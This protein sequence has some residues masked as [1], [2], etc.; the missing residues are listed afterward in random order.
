MESD[1]RKLQLTLLEILDDVIEVFESNNV[2]Y[3]IG[4]G[5]ALGAVRHGGFIP[6]DDD[7]DIAVMVDDEEKMRAAL[8]KLDQKKYSV[9]YPL[10]GEFGE[11]F[12]LVSKKGTTHIVW[13]RT[14]RIQRISIEIFVMYNVPDKKWERSIHHTLMRSFEF[15]SNISACSDSNLVNGIIVKTMKVMT[16]LMDFISMKSKEHYVEPRNNFF[17]RDLMKKEMYGTPRILKFENREICFPEHLEEYL[18]QFYGDYMQ[19]PPEE[20]RVPREY[21][22][23]SFDVDYT[24]YIKQN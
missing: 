18:T 12:Y 2:P 11:G 17:K 5:C 13:P 15:I 7:V 10:D 6:W 3:Y 19:L 24:E 20:K 14:K 1:V 8:S 23:L 4:G 16:K 9:Q 22:A 21:G